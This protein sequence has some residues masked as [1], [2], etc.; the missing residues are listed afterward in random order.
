MLAV[1]SLGCAGYHLGSQTLYAPEIRTVHV[2]IF[3]SDSIRPELGQLLT[4]AVVK[5]I[6]LKTPYKVVGRNRA[7]T[8]LDARIV[9]DLKRVQVE[10]KQDEPR[11]LDV[12]LRIEV[13]W[14]T[15]QGQLLR[16]ELALPVDDTLSRIEPS[17]LLVP[18]V[19]QSVAS[20]QLQ[21]AQRAAEQIVAMMQ[22]PW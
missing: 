18:E 12:D 3:A 21:L 13:R 6:E 9:R 11:A 14:T 19:G 22:V 7:D 5:E 2:P 10:T 17:V 15:S 4:E 1:G 16:P 8:I 20:S